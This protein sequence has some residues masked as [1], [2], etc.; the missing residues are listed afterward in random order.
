[1]TVTFASWTETR[2]RSTFGSLSVE[3]ACDGNADTVSDTGG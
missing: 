3:V 2:I 1:M